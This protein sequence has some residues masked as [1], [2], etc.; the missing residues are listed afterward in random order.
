MAMQNFSRTV[1]LWGASFANAAFAG[2]LG[3]DISAMLFVFAGTFAALAFR[4][5]LD[6]SI[7]R[8]HVPLIH[9]GG[10]CRQYDC[11][12]GS[13]FRYEYNSLKSRLAPAYFSDSGVPMINSTLDCLPAIH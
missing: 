6:K 10:L 9:P 1:L 4:Q 5:F 11:C 3:G 2:Y 8:R 13:T 12:P 7:M